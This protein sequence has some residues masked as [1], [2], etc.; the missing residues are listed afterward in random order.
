QEPE[1]VWHV[2]AGGV[3]GGGQVG[4]LRAA[5]GVVRA[6]R[7]IGAD[8]VAG[9]ARVPEKVAGRVDAD[10]HRPVDALRV[11]PGVDHGGARSRAFAQEVDALVPERAP[12]GVEVV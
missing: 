12:G 1:A 5:R 3:E 7:G 8:L 10:H 6:E 11:A 9:R 4:R 2:R